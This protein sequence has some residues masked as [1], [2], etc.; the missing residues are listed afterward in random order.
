MLTSRASTEGDCSVVHL[1]QQYLAD[2]GISVGGRLPAKIGAQERD[3]YL[4]D[5]ARAFLEARGERFG[6]LLYPPRRE[7]APSYIGGMVW[8]TAFRHGRH[9]IVVFISDDGTFDF[10]R[11][12]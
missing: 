3:G 10:F 2:H 8:A 12:H 11:H 1:A 7:K 4:I 6:D 9:G 5:F